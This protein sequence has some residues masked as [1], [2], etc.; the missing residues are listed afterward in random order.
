MVLYRTGEKLDNI[1]ETEA[2]PDK[3]PTS[4]IPK[5]SI[6]LFFQATFANVSLAVPDIETFDMI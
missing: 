4:Y 2:V 6:K 3:L 1:F 5:W